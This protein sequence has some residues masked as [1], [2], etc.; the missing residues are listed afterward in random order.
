MKEGELYNFALSEYE[1]EAPDGQTRLVYAYFGLTGY[2]SQCLEETFSIM[3]WTN[4]IFKDKL[5][6]NKEIN[7]LIDTFDNSKKTMGNLLHEVKN[8]YNL[9]Q[10]TIDKLWKILSQR[11]YLIHRYFKSEIHLFS[12]DLGKKEMLS[13]FCKYIE[14]VN[15]MDDLLKTFYEDYSEKMG[16]TEEVIQEYTNQMIQEELKREQEYNDEN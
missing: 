11:N 12:S 2:W 9:E 7:E 6:T 14:E 4:R 10:E 3:L 1:L 8:E 5:S 13:F 16:I 15:K